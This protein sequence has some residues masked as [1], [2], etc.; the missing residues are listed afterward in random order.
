MNQ[1]ER[2]AAAIGDLEDAPEHLRLL[3]DREDVRDRAAGNTDNE[4]QRDLR[5][6]AD[7]IEVLTR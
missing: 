4:V 2:V 7:A 6:W 3:A 5:R 1:F